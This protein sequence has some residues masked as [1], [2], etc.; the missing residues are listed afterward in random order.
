M[1]YPVANLGTGI[2]GPARPVLGRN[3]QA[4]AKAAALYEKVQASYPNLVAL[5]GQEK[6]DEIVRQARENLANAERA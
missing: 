5:V 2:L 1:R 6:A 3:D 4:V